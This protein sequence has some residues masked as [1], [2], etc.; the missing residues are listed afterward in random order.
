[1]RPIDKAFEAKDRKNG[2]IQNLHVYTAS[3]M[4]LLSVLIQELMLL[5]VLSVLTLVLCLLMI[6]MR[7][8]DRVLGSPVGRWRVVADVENE[9]SV[10]LV[11]VFGQRGR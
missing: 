2:A 8:V 3:S 10:S 1:M 5:C 9:A 4:W 11:G 6:Y 7:L